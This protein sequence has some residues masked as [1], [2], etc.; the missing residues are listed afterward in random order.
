MR[1]LPWSVSAHAKDIW[2]IPDWEK[3]DKLAS[4]AWAVTCT[5]HGR[6]HL[7]ALAP[8]PGIVSLAY[9]GLDFDRFPPQRHAAAV[10]ADGGDPARPVVMLSV[11][12]AV[13]KKGYDDLLHGAGAAAAWILPGVSSISAAA[14][15]RIGSSAKP[16]G[17]GLPAVSNGAAR[18]R[19]RTCLPPTARPICSCSPP[20]SPATA[21]A[22]GCPT[23]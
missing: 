21:T 9:H 17:S 13:A 8:S 19:S 16:R 14:R 2:T 11:G 1:G 5:S 23:C 22:T 20:R 15:W 7:A 18:G 12:R 10:T 3:R 4:A 6:D